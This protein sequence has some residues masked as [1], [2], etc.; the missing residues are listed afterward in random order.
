MI[1][2]G[3]NIVVGKS[4]PGWGVVITLISNSET[5]NIN[6]KYLKR[7]MYNSPHV[8]TCIFAQNY[9]TVQIQVRVIFTT[10]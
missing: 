2:T 10:D 8:T 1:A 6:N 5:T 3:I 7:P 9:Y 4:W